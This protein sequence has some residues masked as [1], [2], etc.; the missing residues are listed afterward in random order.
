MNCGDC[1]DIWQ[2]DDWP[3]WRYDLAEL[4]Q[5]LAEVS[6]AQGRLTALRDIGDLLTRGILR[7]SQGGGRSTSY[8]LGDM[9]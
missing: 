6:L 8:E 7:K 9:P 3:R 5:P 1:V 2:H 4:A